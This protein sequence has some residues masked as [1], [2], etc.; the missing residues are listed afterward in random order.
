VAAYVDPAAALELTGSGSC[1]GQILDHR[2]GTGGFGYD[3]LFIIPVL[4]RTMAEMDLPEKN[5]LSHRAAAFRALLAL[6]R[7]R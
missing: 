7:G 4:G 2:Q 1:E 3:P 5:S 6:L